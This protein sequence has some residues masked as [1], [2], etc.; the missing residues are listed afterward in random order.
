MKKY[1]FF[2]LILFL[3]AGSVFAWPSF[4]ITSKSSPDV[5]FLEGESSCS[6][7]LVFIRAAAYD[8]SEIYSAGFR[9]K[10]KTNSDV[11]GTIMNRVGTISIDVGGVPVSFDLY[12]GYTTP[13]GLEG[14]THTVDV[15]A[16]D[17]LYAIAINKLGH[18]TTIPNVCP[19]TVAGEGQ[20]EWTVPPSEANPGDDI[21]LGAILYNADN[22]PVAGEMLTFYDVTADNFEIGGGTTD[23]NGYAE[24][25]YHIPV[26]GVPGPH[27][28]QARYA[29]NPGIGV[30]PTQSD[31]LTLTII[32]KT[33]ICEESSSGVTGVTICIHPDFCFVPAK[34]TQ[35][36]LVVSPNPQRAGLCISLDAHLGDISNNPIVGQTIV[37]KDGNVFVGADQTDEAGNVP[38]WYCI[39]LDAALGTHTI[40]AIFAGSNENE[41]NENQFLSSQAFFNLLVTSP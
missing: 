24:T 13:T 38:G 11:G 5:Y 8:I 22:S 36:S 20:I 31:Y 30:L 1:L 2:T 27:S 28:L 26:Y 29:G 3:L 32:G 6:A 10:D 33:W 19:F 21:L 40:K 34:Q 7:S 18:I 23:S 17:K 35:L 4:E 39:P 16:T 15:Y 12:E 9:I 41:C 14:G 37:F 25:T